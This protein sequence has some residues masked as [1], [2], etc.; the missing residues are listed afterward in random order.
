MKLIISQYLASLKERDELDAILPDLLSE[1]GLNVYSRPG[2]GTR[3]D[4]VDV[5]AVGC[6][7]GETE[8]VYLFSIKAGDLTRHSWDGD[9]LQ[10]LRPSL[11]EILDSYIPNRLPDEHKEKDIVICLCFGGG[12]KEQVRPSVEGYI[13]KNKRNNIAFEEWNG[14]KLASLIQSNFLSP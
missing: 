4:G 6:L 1:I 9:A 7:P 8:K 14:D 13:K 5:A 2:R 11:N 3:Q 10:S 12:I